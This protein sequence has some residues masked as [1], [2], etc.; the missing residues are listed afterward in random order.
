[1]QHVRVGCGHLAHRAEP[2]RGGRFEIILG[3]AFDQL[4][5]I[6]SRYARISLFFRQ[7]GPSQ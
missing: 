6:T 1:M 3:E 7:I 5:V 2:H 4:F